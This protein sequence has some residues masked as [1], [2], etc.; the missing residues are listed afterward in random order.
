MPRS[1]D[2]E[3]LRGAVAV[4]VDGSEHARRA[5]GWAADQAALEHRRLTVLA[6]AVTGDDATTAPDAA[7]EA[8]DA[9]RALHPEGPVVSLVGVG[10]PRQL[11]VDA[12]A[13]THM[14]VL[15]SRGR[16]PLS[17]MLLG[18]VSAAVS[19]HAACPVVVCRPLQDV[20]RRGGVVVGADGTP[21]SLPVVE[22]AYRQA[23]LRG[24]PLT[25]LH[26]VY[27]AV[28]VAARARSTDDA[29]PD[30][31]GLEQL[32]AALAES[33]AGL[34]EDYPGVPV[35]LTVRQGLADQALDPRH[36][37]W[38]LIVVG[39]HP[40]TS[41]DRVLTGAVAIAVLERADAPVAVVPEARPRRT[42]P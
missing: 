18:S 31:P 17:S 26:S 10:D 11:L 2:P 12:S 3:H 4:A 24:E 21:E 36:G 27:D 22:F 9:A 29:E 28:A 37:G 33:V 35:T 40:M 13:H 30:V 15:G 23:F 32:H 1:W 7:A 14:V 6:V 5:V 38:E 16:G 25:V 41:L 34:S 20:E 19:A 8:V 42:T 39:R